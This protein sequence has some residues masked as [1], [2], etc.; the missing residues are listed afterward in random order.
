MGGSLFCGYEEGG[1]WQKSHSSVNIMYFVI[2]IILTYIVQKKTSDFISF[3]GGEGGENHRHCVC[4][5]MCA[6]QYT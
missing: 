6:L 2:L 5:C 3:E 4:V 1:I